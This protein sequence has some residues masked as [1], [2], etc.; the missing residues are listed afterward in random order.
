MN[1]LMHEKLI[2]HKMDT[3]RSVSRLFNSPGEIEADIKFNTSS[4]HILG[5]CGYQTINTLSWIQLK[6][7]LWHKLL[8]V[9]V[10]GATY[11]IL[12]NLIIVANMLRKDKN[13]SASHLTYFENCPIVNYFGI[14]PNNYP[15]LVK[16]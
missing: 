13:K 15:A 16:T 9:H 11:E 8:L 6:S 2:E 1:S 10:I 3:C 5:Q 12:E 4:D 14:K 7:N